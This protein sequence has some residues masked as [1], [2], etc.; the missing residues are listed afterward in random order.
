MYVATFI[1]GLILGLLFPREH[2]N[3]DK[4]Q[5]YRQKCVSNH[6]TMCLIAMLSLWGADQRADVECCGPGIG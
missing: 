3:I 4:E 2:K 5:K 6:S 1:G